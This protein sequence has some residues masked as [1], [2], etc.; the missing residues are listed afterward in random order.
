MLALPLP[1]KAAE[2]DERHPPPVAL[3]IPRVCP[4]HQRDALALRETAHVEQHRAVRERREVFLR[5]GDAPGLAGLVPA[6]RVLH[7]PPPPEG[8]PLAS[9]QGAAVEAAGL[10]AV[11]RPHDA[12][13][14]YAEQGG[15]TVHRIRRED[16]KAAAAAGPRAE[17]L[18]PP[19]PPRPLPGPPPVRRAPHEE[20]PPAGGPH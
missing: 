3:A 17:T 5:V 1:G 18:R 12:L 8:D 7:E 6:A 2:Q 9:G 14:L 20:L 4:D 16:E 19:P 15:H 13:R 10:E 11:R